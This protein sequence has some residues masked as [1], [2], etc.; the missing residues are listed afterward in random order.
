VPDGRDVTQ[1][2][3]RSL[4]EHTSQRAKVAE[5]AA[6]FPVTHWLAFIDQAEQPHGSRGLFQP[7]HVAVQFRGMTT[8]SHDD[9]LIHAAGHRF[10]Q[11]VR[12]VPLSSTFGSD[13]RR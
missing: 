5:D 6:S 7:S 13:A 11:R 4:N 10:P 3:A 8:R 1:R 2:S 12:K 9:N